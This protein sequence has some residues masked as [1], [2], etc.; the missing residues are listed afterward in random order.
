MILTEDL[1]YEYTWELLK[2]YDVSFNYRVV[3]NFFQETFENASDFLDQLHDV[4]IEVLDD[5]YNLLDQIADDLRSF[6][7]LTTDSQRFTIAKH[8]VY[9]H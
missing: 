5:M 3:F 9:E 6:D 8:I 1:L 4:Y 2:V 7:F